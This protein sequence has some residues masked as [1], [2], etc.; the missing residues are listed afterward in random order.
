MVKKTIQA[1][2]VV[3]FIFGSFFNPV[4]SQSVLASR[5]M[6]LNN[7]YD[8]SFVNDVFKDNILLT[9]AYMRGNVTKV[10]DPF[11]YEFRL[12]PSRTFAFH[13]DVAEKYNN[14]LVKTT[15]ARFNAAD[16]FKTDGYL[17]GDGVCHLASLIYW[18]ARDAGLAA[19]APTNHNF[20]NI[21]D[22]PKE[23]GV[24]I[25]NSPGSKSSNALQNLY[26]TNNK[27]KPI[28]FRFEYNNNKIKVS[29]MKLN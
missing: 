2:A 1:F 13:G 5:E 17:F 23:Y 28:D 9:L 11:I 29:V 3:P 12:E 15:N 7:R 25:Y 16:G 19:E 27:E 20:A 10:S 14:S 8:N 24:S 26:I 21:P 4:P 18:V 6:S 22:V